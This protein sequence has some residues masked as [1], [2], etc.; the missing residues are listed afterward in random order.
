MTK[1]TH[2]LYAKLRGVSHALIVLSLLLAFRAVPAAAATASITGGTYGADCDSGGYFT[3]SSTTVISGDTVTISVPVNDPYSGGMEVHGF[4]QGSFVVARG[5]SVTTSPL[6]STVSYY[7]TWPTSG[8]MKG[9]GTIT[10]KA[11]AAPSVPASPKT[12]TGSSSPTNTSTPAASS[13]TPTTSSSTDSSNPSSTA[14]AT[15]KKRIK[16]A[17]VQTDVQNPST[18]NVAAIG[19]GVAVVI[20]IGLFMVWQLVIRPRRRAAR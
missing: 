4:P 10:V 11:A 9:S 8:C 1:T 19:G 17:P 14:G 12:P 20:I 5:S 13:T 18:K 6:T 7:G 15:A 2:S 3:P 16:S